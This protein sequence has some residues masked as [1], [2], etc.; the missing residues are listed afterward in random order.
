MNFFEGELVWV[1]DGTH[2]EYANI[3]SISPNGALNIKWLKNT[4]IS[5]PATIAHVP[6]SYMVYA[7]LRYIHMP[8]ALLKGY[9]GECYHHSLNNGWNIKIILDGDAWKVAK[10]SSPGVLDSWH[11]VGTVGD[12]QKLMSIWHNA[13][14]EIDAN[15]IFQNWPIWTVEFDLVNRYSLMITSTKVQERAA[16]YNAMSG[17][18]SRTRFFMDI[19][20]YWIG[21]YHYNNYCIT[22][23]KTDLQ[24][25]RY[26]YAE[27]D[28][29]SGSSS[30]SSE[31]ANIDLLIAKCK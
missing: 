1:T 11:N 10:E 30:M 16:G 17:L 27:S 26:H 9:T 22:K 6:L 14:Y 8:D 7:D 28:R 2:A 18:L 21:L 15:R 13:K 19:C 5:Q 29:I 3:E 12:V 24:K 4:R 25:A 31:I 20:H 23:G